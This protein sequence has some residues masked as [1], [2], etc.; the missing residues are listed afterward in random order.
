MDALH[1]SG[2]VRPTGNQ[3]TARVAGYRISA[4]LTV[5]VSIDPK[6]EDTL[7]V[8]VA[9]GGVVDD[10]G[11]FAFTL[12]GDGA[13]KAPLALT[14]ATP[15]GEQ[16]LQ[17][18]FDLEEAS[19]P[20]T[21]RVPKLTQ[22]TIGRSDDPT[23]GE[24]VMLS[25]R[26]I[27]SRGAAVAAGVPVI[28]WGVV[29]D[30]AS[31]T[32]QPLVISKTQSGGYFSAP[33]I[34][35]PLASAFGR[36]AG[37]DPVP[38]QTDDLRLPRRVL[39]VL[40]V[41]DTE[42]DDSNNPPR[43]PDPADLTRNPAAFSQ[44]L[45]R[46]CINLSTPNR[47]IEEFSYTTV[48]R[49]SEPEVRG[50]TLGLRLRVPP[51]MLADLVQA[52]AMRETLM[53]GA[54]REQDVAGLNDLSLDVATARTLAAGDHPPLLADIKRAAWL[55]EF[56]R[57]KD[58]IGAAV[59]VSS[60]RQPLDADRAIDWDETPTLFEAITIARGHLLEFREVWRA[61][62]YS[63]GDL[64]YSLPLAPG[65]RRQIAIVDWER[66]STTTREE[67]LDYEEQLDALVSRD[68]DV[69]EIVGSRLGEESAGA[70]SNTTWGVSG[71]IGAGFIG[72]GFGI[73]G[74][75][76]GSAGGSSSTAWQESSRR[77][78]AD[79]LQ[80]LRDRVMQRASSVRD[81]RSTTVQTA[82]QG[83][84]LRAETE[85]VANYNRCH[86][87]TVEYFEVLRHFVI[88][89]EL[90]DVRECL[91]VPLP[92][93]EFDAGKALRWQTPLVAHLRERTLLPAFNALRRIA[94]NWEGWD[95]PVGRY[96]SEA[97]QSL[98]GELRISF[99]LPR[100][101]DANDGTFQVDMW[102][103]YRPWLWMD[104]Y[105]LWTQMLQEGIADFNAGEIA[106]RDIN[107]RTKVAPELAKRMM[108]RLRFWYVTSAGS[109]V[110]VA[111]D[112]TLVS[113][114]AE[115]VPL[116]VT[117][118]P[119]GGLSAIPREQIVQFKITLDGA[120]L[121]PDAQVIIHSGKVRYQT[122]HKQW[123]L[124]SDDRILNDISNTDPVYVSTPTSW[125]EN[126]DPRQEDYDLRD[127]LM[128]HLNAGLEYYHQVIWVW[129]DAERRFMLLDGILVSG[130]G[131]KS[132]A[133][134][135]ENRLIGIA[136]NSLIMPLAPGI[137]IDP[138]VDSESEGDLI[139]LYNADSPPPMRVSVPTRG[140]YA[141]AIL[142]GCEACEEIDDSRYWRWQTEGM[143][144]PPTI[145]PVDTA[146]RATPEDPL[147]PTPL[148]TPLVSI[149]NAPDLPNPVGLGEIL[150]ILAKPDLFTDI[151]G[152][153]GTQKN[154]RAG[155][156]A[157]LSAASGVASQAAAM[158]KQEMTSRDGERMLDR[159]V[160]AQDSGLLTPGAAQDLSSKVFGAMV[161]APDDK[162]DKKAA[163]PA[164]D[165]AVQK[166]LDKAAQADKGAIKVS[167][168]D[169]S[170][171]M[172]FDG[173]D[174]AIGGALGSPAVLD[175]DQWIAQPVIKD[176]V[177]FSPGNLCD[178][179]STTLDTLVA[180]MA[181]FPAAIVPVLGRFVRGRPGAPTKYD[182][183]GR[184]RIVYPADPADAKKVGGSGRLPLAVLVHGQHESW[185][186]GEVRNHDGYSYLQDHLAKQGIVSVSVDTNA[187]NY[188]DSLI[189][190]RAL[191]ALKAIDSLRAQDQDKNSRFYRRLDF[192]RIGLM[193]HSRGGDAVARAVTLNAGNKHGVIRC[194]A[195]VAPTDFTGRQV[196]SRRATLAASDTGFAFVL[197]GGLDGDVSGMDGATAFVGTGFRHYD[198]SKAAG[199]M[200][201]VPGC[202][203]N[204]FNR[205]WSADDGGL[206]PADLPRVHSRTDHEQ[207][208]IEYVGGLFE[209]K[210]RDVVARSAL[211]DGRGVNTL[212][213]E[214]SLQWKWG[215]QRKVLDDFELPTKATI[216]P[217]TLH[218][219]EVKAFADVDL[220]GAPAD[221][222]TPHQTSIAALIKN[223]PAPVAVA[224]EIDLPTGQRDWS[225]YLLLTLRLGTSMN[226]TSAATIAAGISP[227]PLTL[228]LIDGAGKSGSVSEVAFT[229]TELPGKPFF[230]ESVDYNHGGIGN[231]TLHRLATATITLTGFAVNLSDVRTLQVLPTAAFG[232]RIFIDSLQLVKP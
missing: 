133:S 45:G 214:A 151:T 107:F 196:E 230:H 210:L 217:R 36:V 30:D 146:S 86:A 155:F 25:G 224:I 58:L 94:D 63:L 228:T 99:V 173:G 71:G 28:L 232:Q 121:P 167:T 117:L 157:A 200:V 39:L 93:R 6:R 227:P 97:P 195:M 153:E 11:A 20:L 134:L 24:R 106:K 132:I 118:R 29:A 105:E 194:V 197:Y 27:D 125:A 114:Y 136:G 185:E 152:L 154:A 124:F 176:T 126:R 113:R 102:K 101:R 91:F 231:C 55:S 130:Q 142:G 166:A 90:A 54:I 69:S 212:G 221:V 191:I 119:N 8:P 103:H 180:L 43:V 2:I 47:V 207:L 33:W 222:H 96:S 218:D 49:T 60:G 26:V 51:K 21:L 187:A 201:F 192:D 189:E 177:V 76:A 67:A 66:R 52:S 127:R 17:R 216:G 115:G 59:G 128:V 123:L 215:A 213:H 202:I 178:I 204:R 35:T 120:D 162:A 206:L 147:T 183:F 77:F 19:R 78:S 203:H 72:T 64:L 138:R 163:S 48:V 40:E 37:S 111:L 122:E 193:G 208:M 168:L 82:A 172:S 129:L 144:A 148:P 9:G 149:Q 112:A 158:A 12:L 16:V 18:Q 62:G 219:C 31:A 68:R 65:Q 32:P 179:K 79:S 160:R 4:S 5:Q 100:P 22:V 145:E 7:D 159:I 15:E 14:V 74:G 164:A 188:F 220:D 137:H 170:I 150:K 23:L 13:A 116:Y 156:D 186:S 104:P 80:S 50:I 229:T 95:Y 88:T 46:G 75:V 84:T 70:S 198:R 56:S 131:G 73:F 92:M 110:E 141:E 209:W 182:V 225:G 109:E 41:P 226:I 175:L 85:T 211:F 1:I 190:M 184:L 44:D 3:K 42:N 140:V 108:D 87:M 89:H 139:D 161:G 181:A 165:P 143:L 34:S 38:I 98:E 205:T 61:D 169:E 171:E 199:A 10:S 57:V 174:T 223:A 83:E 81:Q 135:V 53:R